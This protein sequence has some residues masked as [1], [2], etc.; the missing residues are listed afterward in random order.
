M[1]KF[2][3]ILDIPLIPETFEPI[4]MELL[5]GQ[6]DTDGNYM[7]KTVHYTLHERH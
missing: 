7:I 4:T 5:L 6:F 3:A 2:S 1:V